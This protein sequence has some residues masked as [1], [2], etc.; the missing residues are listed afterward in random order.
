MID[1]NDKEL[2]QEVINKSSSRV[3]VLKNF[4]YNPKSA[5]SRKKLNKS[6]EKFGLDISHFS[7]RTDRW[8]ILPDVIED[9][10]SI[11][12]VLKM[13]GLTDQGDNHK[14][15]KR[16]IKELG[17]D[18]SHFRKP[19]RAN[20]GGSLP[21]YTAEEMFCENSRVTRATVKRWILRNNVIEYKCN[22]CGIVEWNGRTLTLDLDHINGINNDHRIE[23]LRFLCPNC[24]S[25]TE[26]H[27]GRN[28]NNLRVV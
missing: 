10:Y 6:I 26:T 2:L 13:V 23:N 25:L 14:T 11:A 1:W 16:A 21:K 22:E 4:G 3:E 28:K 17:L 8:N 27:R 12:D 15:A 20:K 7:N 24:H 5:I 19:D 9:C 18:I